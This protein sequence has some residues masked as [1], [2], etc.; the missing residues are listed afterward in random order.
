MN[1]NNAYLND[2]NLLTLFSLNN[3]IVPE[4][5]REYVWGSLQN[6]DKIVK[7][8][9]DILPSDNCSQCGFTHSCEDKNIGFL[10]SYKP[11]YARM[12]NNRFQDEY[13]IDGQQRI[14]TVFLLLIVCAVREKRVKDFISICRFDSDSSSLCFQYKVRDL[15]SHFIFQL[16]KRIC[17]WSDSSSKANDFFSFLDTKKEYPT[18]ILHDYCNDSTVRNMLNALHIIRNTLEDECYRHNKYFDYLLCHIR[19][20]H[21]KTDVTSQGEELYITMNARGEQLVKNETLKAE[22]FKN[23]DQVKWGRKWEM[24]Q[25]FFWQYKDK[26][27]VDAGPGLDSYLNCIFELERYIIKRTVS[28]RSKINWTIE[29]DRSSKY[30]PKLSIDIVD[31]YIDA[32]LHLV[33]LLNDKEKLA[34]TGLFTDWVEDCKNQIINLIN[35]GSDWFLPFESQTLRNLSSLQVN[36]QLLW[37]W[38]Y[39]YKCIG[40]N[41]DTKELLR[42]IHFFYI[43]FKQG[44]RTATTIIDVV[45]NIVNGKDKCAPGFCKENISLSES[46]QSNEESLL[47]KICEDIEN[48]KLVWQILNI[49]VLRDVK[50]IVAYPCVSLYILDDVNYRNQLYKILHIFTALQDSINKNDKR[51]LNLIRSNLLYLDPWPWKENYGRQYNCSDWLYIIKNGFVKLYRQLD[52]NLSTDKLQCL[53]D[54][55]RA[56]LLKISSLDNIEWKDRVRICDAVALNF[57]DLEGFQ[58]FNWS[59]IWQYQYNKKSYSELIIPDNWYEIIKESLPCEGSVN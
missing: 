59:D 42:F 56:S 34:E 39:Y 6:E 1:K 37:S 40:K 13:L 4:M 7:L 52:E 15:T 53:L 32:L 26:N 57:W 27:A 33:S 48:E 45:D 20:W 38:M 17:E 12:E 35:N 25:D 9:T 28:Q 21:F 5:Q 29:E 22:L 19:F 18:W 54:K 51:I 31:I 8:L 44:R 10:Y 58:T 46:D 47:L 11:T 36:L 3:L 16:L 43:R 30:E 41:I 50:T 55:E 2:D 23:K 14:T 24:W 49:P